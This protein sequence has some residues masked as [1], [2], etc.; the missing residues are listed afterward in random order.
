MS[1]NETREHPEGGQAQTPPE[2]TFENPPLQDVLVPMDSAG[3]G[4]HGLKQIMPIIQC[5]RATLHALYVRRSPGVYKRDR[6]RFDP[7]EQ[8]EQLSEQFEHSMEELGLDVTSSIRK[9]TPQSEILTYA[10]ENDV[11]LILMTTH[12]RTGINR[13]FHGSVTEDVVRKSPVPVMA[14]TYED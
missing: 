3:I 7:D 5:C 11:D 8:L 4:Q 13:I 14:V 12:G 2:F 6:L 1:S 10:R 9:G